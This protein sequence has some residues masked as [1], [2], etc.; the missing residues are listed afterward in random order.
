MHFH[1]K[2][3]SKFTMVVREYEVNIPYGLIEIKKI[4]LLR[5]LKNLKLVIT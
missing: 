1:I 5:W 3:K 4:R 2:N